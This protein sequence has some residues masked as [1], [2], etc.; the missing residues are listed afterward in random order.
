MLTLGPTGSS[1]IPGKTISWLDQIQGLLDSTGH[2][3]GDVTGLFAFLEQGQV[4]PEGGC[5]C[6]H[7]YH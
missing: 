2:L 3:G 7:H 1:A 4:H 5:G 6:H